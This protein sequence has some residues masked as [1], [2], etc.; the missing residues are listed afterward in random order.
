MTINWEAL[1]TFSLLDHKPVL[2]Y[3]DTYDDWFACWQGVRMTGRQAFVIASE[4]LYS[5]RITPEMRYNLETHFKSLYY[6]NA[7]NT[8]QWDNVVE[9]MET[10]NVQ[11]SILTRRLN[12]QQVTFD[13]TE[14]LGWF[15]KMM[16][17]QCTQN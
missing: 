9:T 2:I 11:R 8:R 15:N 1:E 5:A 6:A 17:Q 12:K 16:E 13:K 7:F 3:N 14:V 4:L 10:T